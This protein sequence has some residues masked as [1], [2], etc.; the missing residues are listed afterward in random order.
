MVIMT[1]M[2]ALNRTVLEWSF[3]PKDFFEEPYELPFEG[4]AITVADGKARGNF[5]GAL[6]VQ[7]REFRDSADRFLRNAFLAHQVQ[8]HQSFSL[9][10]PTMACEQ[11]DG[12]TD[13]TI[14]PD[15]AVLTM[16][17]S[18]PDIKHVA[19]DGTVL[20]DT[21][22]E[23]LERHA[24][25]RAAIVKLLSFDT[26]L[27]RMLESYNNALSD[28]DNLLIHLHEVRETLSGEA[29]TDRAARELTGVSSSDWSKF[30]RLANDEPLL[31]GRHRGK[32]SALRKATKE[33]SDWALEFCQR[34]IEGYVRSRAEKNPSRGRQVK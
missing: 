21:R 1:N 27:K 32:H 30:G 20:V 18:S 6:Y 12:R 31:E 24:T 17:A 3:E 2:S 10:L 19:A 4:G 34:L 25:F 28:R 7:G 8:V 15:S 26:A 22:A 23:R 16:S 5:D 9:T 14:F 33:E 11:S 29:G 13:V